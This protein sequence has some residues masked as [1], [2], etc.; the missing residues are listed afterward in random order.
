MSA[1]TVSEVKL[2]VEFVTSNLCQVISSGVE[3]HAGDQALCAL[4][5]QRLARTDLLIEFEKTFLVVSGRILCQA[6]QN[7]G[8]LTEELDD[9]RVGA[10]AESTDQNSDGN[11][12]CTVYTH[13]ENVIGVRLIFQPCTTVR[14]YCTGIQLFS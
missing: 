11:F 4:Y 5:C 3:E 2:F 6:G 7:L 1:D 9:L 13:I 10:K 14:N 8:L 12:S